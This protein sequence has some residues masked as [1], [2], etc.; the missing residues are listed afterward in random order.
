MLALPPL[1]L[2]YKNTNQSKLYREII[3]GCSENNTKH[4][5]TLSGENVEFFNVK[6]G[7]M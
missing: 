4:K 6:P 1:R 3:A 7:Y 5:N 2:G